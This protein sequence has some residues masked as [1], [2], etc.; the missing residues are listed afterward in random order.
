MGKLPPGARG[1]GQIGQIGQKWTKCQNYHINAISIV[2]VS[3]PRFSR[4]CRFVLQFL[5]ASERV[6]SN[7]KAHTLRCGAGRPTLLKSIHN[8]TVDSLD[9][10]VDPPLCGPLRSSLTTT[11]KRLGYSPSPESRCDCAEV[12]LA[13]LWLQRE[14]TSRGATWKSRLHLYWQPGNPGY[15][16]K[17]C[18]WKME[19]GKQYVHMNHF[20]LGEKTAACEKK[21]HPPLP[22]YFPLSYSYYVIYFSIFQLQ[23][24]T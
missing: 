22:G 17:I 11:R 15:T 7:S 6:T 13:F 14:A 19:N 5:R 21:T 8:R 2:I 1:H 4:N 3:A 24:I 10:F 9:N 16:L 20:T 23:I 18:N 12:D